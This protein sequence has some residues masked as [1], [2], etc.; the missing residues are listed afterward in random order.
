MKLQFTKFNSR[1]ALILLLTTIPF[2]ARGQQTAAQPAAGPCERPPHYHQF[3]FWL[4]EWDV[5]ESSAETG[6]TVGAS[7][8][9]KLVGSCIIQENWE[10]PGFSG[11]SWNFYD[12]GLS[13]WRQIWI[14]IT[15]RRAEFSGE[16]RD[17]AMRFEGEAV[18][19]NGRRVKSRMTFFNLSADKVRQFAERS[20]DEGKT[21]TTTVDYIYFR[22]K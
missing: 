16:Y 21:W 5:K 11:K 9:E 19:A 22:K 14:D 18:L 4:G 3:D 12:V 17:G 2:V 1:I 10:S 20:T 6:P 15:G 8:I 13:K 7:K